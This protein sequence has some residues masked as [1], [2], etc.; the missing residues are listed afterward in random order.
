MVELAPPQGRP[1][2]STF[3]KPFLH[4]MLVCCRARMKLRWEAVANEMARGHPSASRVTRAASTK[5]DTHENPEK[6]K[7]VG[8]QQR[9]EGGIH[10][11]SESDACSWGPALHELRSSAHRH[12]EDVDEKVAR[13]KTSTRKVHAAPQSTERIQRTSRVLSQRS[14]TSASRRPSFSFFA[15]AC[16]D[17]VLESRGRIP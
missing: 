17:A 2:S 15:Q 6:R 16:F 4:V 11:N 14:T 9:C 12:R 5:C 10:H 7:C 3:Q 13:I 8:L 1:P